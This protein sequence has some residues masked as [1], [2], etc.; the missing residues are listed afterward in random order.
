MKILLAWYSRSGTTERAAGLAAELLRDEGHR[1]TEFPIRPLWDLDYFLWLALSFYPGSRFPLQEELPRPSEF[2]ACLLALPKWT[3]SCAPVNEFLAQRGRQLPPTAV[4]V[5]CG[6][7]DQDRYLAEL[8]D[9]LKAL[10]VR[11]L[12]GLTLKRKRIDE[13][14]L[15]GEL[16]EFLRV[17]FPR[18]AGPEPT[19]GEDAAPG[20][21]ERP[22]RAGQ[23]EQQDR[24]QPEDVAR[25]A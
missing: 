10:N 1:V 2:D 25:E 20:R 11:V 19:A 15:G 13:G 18:P 7:W 5:T 23:E 3:L 22:L 4:L 16:A 6:G 9:Q 14:T 17:S 8:Q 24:A 12:G 21:R